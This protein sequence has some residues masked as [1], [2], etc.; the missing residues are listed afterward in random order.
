MNKHQIVS[1][2][3]LLLL[4]M[5]TALGVVYAKHQSRRL[6]VE[7][8]KQQHLSDE[9]MVEW[10]RLKLEESAWSSDGRIDQIARNKL[11]MY[12]PKADAVVVVETR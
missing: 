6:F 9:M 2:I 10:G 8:Q 12:I 5:V 11:D 7:L 3:V 1:R 4:V